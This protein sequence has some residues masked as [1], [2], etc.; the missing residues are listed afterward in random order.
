[1]I[2]SSDEDILVDQFG[3]IELNFLQFESNQLDRASLTLS[4]LKKI[5]YFQIKKKANNFYL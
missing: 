3:S 1:M 5:K 2:H 4:R